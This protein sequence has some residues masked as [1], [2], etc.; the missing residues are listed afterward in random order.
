MAE[1]Q[2][3]QQQQQQQPEYFCD[4]CQKKLNVSRE[5]EWNV[6]RCGVRD[7]GASAVE[8]FERVLKR[9]MEADLYECEQCLGH[10]ESTSDSD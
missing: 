5:I 7:Y 6:Q 8:N 9:A 10:D 3:Q 4:K 1:Q 2:Q